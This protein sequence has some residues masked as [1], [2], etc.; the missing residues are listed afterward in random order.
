VLEDL[1]VID[2]PAIHVRRTLGGDVYS[3]D[4]IDGATIKRV[5]DEAAARPSRRSARTSRSSR[6]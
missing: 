2:A 1:L 3:L 4:Q 6:A 5:I